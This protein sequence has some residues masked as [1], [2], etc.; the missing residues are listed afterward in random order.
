MFQDFNVHISIDAR[1]FKSA[2]ERYTQIS[3]ETI[4]KH[5]MSLE[6]YMKD[7]DSQLHEKYMK[8]EKG[9]RLADKLSFYFI[10]LKV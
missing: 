10:D 3:Y 7:Y 8:M 6:E 2:Y 4:K 1:P 5:Q 9:S